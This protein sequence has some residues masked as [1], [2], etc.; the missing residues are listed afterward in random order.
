MTVTMTRPFCRI[1]F[2]WNADL[3]D[4]AFTAVGVEDDE[5]D[6]IIAANGHEGVSVDGWETEVA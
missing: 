2:T 6:A 3:T 1:I 5:I 4:C